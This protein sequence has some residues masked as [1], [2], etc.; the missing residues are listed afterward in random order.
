MSTLSKQI[1]ERVELLMF[2]N[3]RRNR[4]E[5]AAVLGMSAPTVSRRLSGQN[6]FTPDELQAM[7][8]W[9]GVPVR[10]LIEGKEIRA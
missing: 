3:G 6:S 9:L 1:A 2:L 4:A 8:D 10:E 7:A 5:L